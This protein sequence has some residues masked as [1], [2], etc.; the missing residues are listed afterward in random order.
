MKIDCP[1]GN[2]ISDNTDALPCKGYVLADEDFF[3]VLDKLDSVIENVSAAQE[4]VGTA[5]RDAQHALISK[6]RGIWVCRDCG[7]IALD[8]AQCQLHWFSP[9]ESK[10]I[11]ILLSARQP[12]S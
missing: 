1:C 4:T 7:R 2:E 5:K 10:F 3:P 12:N 9:D 11:E 8:D 6:F